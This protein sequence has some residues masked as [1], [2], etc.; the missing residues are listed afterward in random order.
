M[1]GQLSSKR[2]SKQK[3]QTEIRGP[4]EGSPEGSRNTQGSSA[5]NSAGI[6]FENRFSRRS[7]SK[8][9]EHYDKD[10]GI[11]MPVDPN[12]RMELTVEENAGRIDTIERQLDSLSGIITDRKRKRSKK[13]RNSGDRSSP[14]SN[15]G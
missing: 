4:L 9:D 11:S 2:S 14:E 6:K 10:F 7:G 5:C 1:K 13:A 15:V 8:F 3:N 12:T